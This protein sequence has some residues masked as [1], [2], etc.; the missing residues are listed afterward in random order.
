MSIQG[1]GR[2]IEKFTIS[3]GIGLGEHGRNMEEIQESRHAQ[4]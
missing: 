2:T 4:Y 3:S 1:N